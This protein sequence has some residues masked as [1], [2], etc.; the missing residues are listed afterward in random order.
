MVTLL[1]VIDAVIRPKFRRYKAA[2]CLDRR[3]K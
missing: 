1:I 3:Q 2:F